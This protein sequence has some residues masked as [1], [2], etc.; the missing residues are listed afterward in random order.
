ML[1]ENAKAAHERLQNAAVARVNLTEA[2]DLLALQKELSAKAMKFHALVA[3]A[4]LLR[5]NGVFLSPS[6]DTKGMRK[7]IDTLRKRFDEKTSSST[8]TQ[9]KHWTGLQAALDSA[10]VTLEVEQRQD[11]KN[12]FGTRLFAGLAP[13]Q[14]K[15][16]L[17]QTPDNKVAMG[18]YERLYEKFAR[19]R[20]AV[21]DTKEILD[22]VHR[23]S[24]ALT[25]IIFDEN[26]PTEVELFFKAIPSGACLDLLTAE[27]VEWL[28]AQG[29]LG[30][31]V[32]RARA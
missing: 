18:Q 14:R 21:A 20:H 27:V 10:I 1:L 22:E 2:Q 29:L 3:R 4:L 16:S 11:W 32:V 8:L 6:P 17:V 31:F 25:N 15:V 30:S 26:V 28:R 12:Y 9:G 19:Y 24:E 7:A 13:E 23:C 5:E